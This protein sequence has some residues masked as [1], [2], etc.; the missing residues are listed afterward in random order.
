MKYKLTIE[1]IILLREYEHENK[2]ILIN[3]FKR[4]LEHI[5]DSEIK[6]LGVS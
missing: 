3:Q 1:E 6:E 2:E 4:S 5:D